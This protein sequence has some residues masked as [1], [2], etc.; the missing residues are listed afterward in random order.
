MTFVQ[1]ESSQPEFERAGWDLEYILFGLNIGPNDDMFE[2]FPSDNERNE[3]DNYFNHNIRFNDKMTDYFPSYS[4]RNMGF[5][6][7]E[8]DKITIKCFSFLLHYF[9][10]LMF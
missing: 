2:S 5:V 8:P 9:L 7:L 3:D 1:S 6:D 10:I 4:E